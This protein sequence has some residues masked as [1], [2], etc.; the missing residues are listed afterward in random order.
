[1]IVLALACF[2]IWHSGHVPQS[3]SSRA[4]QAL[5]MLEEQWRQAQQANDT[6]A[7]RR[8]LAPEL[9]FIGTSGSLRDVDGYIA[10]RSASWIPRAATYTIAEVRVRVYHEVAIVTGK[11]ATAGEAVAN[12]GRFTHVWVRRQRLWHLVAIQRTD[13]AS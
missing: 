7:F 4:V 2:S 9:T 6:M 8:L 3:D 13:I 12:T 1:M 10:S 5:L 11:E